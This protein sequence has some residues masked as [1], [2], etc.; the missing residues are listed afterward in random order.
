MNY[1]N[2][3]KAHGTGEWANRRKNIQ[4][5]CEHDCVYC[6]AKKMLVPKP[7][8]R[9]TAAT[10]KYPRLREHEINKGYRKVAG[11][12]MYP[13]SHDITELYIEN[14]VHELRGMLKADNQL[15]IVSKPHLVCI[16]RICSEFKEY[17]DQITF[18]F[19]IG[20][21]DNAV[22]KYYEPGAPKFEERLECLKY[23]FNNGFKV[24]VS[25][26]PMLDLSPD[27]LYMA[28]EPYVNDTIWFGY[29]NVNANIKI[30]NPTNHAQIKGR[31]RELLNK[32]DNQFI[33][34]L[35]Q[36]LKS[37]PRVRWKDSLKIV[38]DLERPTDKGL[39]I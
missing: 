14:H 38:L 8:N 24:G 37:D 11:I 10:W 28:I 29:L 26:E 18:R 5:G 17:K 9:V 33:H 30:N 21:T 7:A 1:T 20:S 15:L 31:I 12:T 4:T 32:Q 27:R 39:N 35:Y 22:L 2:N 6:Y 3:K 34:D 13:T 19:T 36:S 16:E 25:C 23:A